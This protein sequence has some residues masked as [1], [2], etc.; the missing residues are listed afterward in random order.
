MN[1]CALHMYSVVHIGL[2]HIKMSSLGV[3]WNTVT[4]IAIVVE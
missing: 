3:D 4:R 1:T 2:Y